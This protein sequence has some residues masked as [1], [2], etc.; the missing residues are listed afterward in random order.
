MSKDLF[1]I[2]TRCYLNHSIE[3]AFKKKG[4]GVHV[5]LHLIIYHFVIGIFLYLIIMKARKLEGRQLSQ[6]H[7]FRLLLD[8]VECLMKY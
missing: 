8:L 5:S 6:V 7:C 1:I 3:K 4:Y 2:D